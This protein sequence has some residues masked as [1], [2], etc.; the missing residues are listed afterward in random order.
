MYRKVNY[1]LERQPY[2]SPSSPA[3]LLLAFHSSFS[4]SVNTTSVDHEKAKKAKKELIS[5]R[6]ELNGSWVMDALIHETNL[7]RLTIEE[8]FIELHPLSK[9]QQN[10]IKANN[11]DSTAKKTHNTV[12]HER[13]MNPIIVKLNCILRFFSARFLLACSLC[14]FLDGWFMYHVILF[15]PFMCNI[16]HEEWENLDS[17][18]WFQKL[19]N[20][21]VLL[22]PCKAFPFLR[23]IEIAKKEGIIQSYDNKRPNKRD[24]LT[25]TGARYDEIFELDC[26]SLS[27]SD[28]IEFVLCA[29]H[30]DERWWLDVDTGQVRTSCCLEWK[31]YR[32]ADSC[33]WN[34]KRKFSAFSKSR[35]ILYV[36]V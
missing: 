5:T 23:I 10:V 35:P 15:S 16:H 18:L 12:Q 6:D 31:I 4:L 13:E 32:M 2:V 30:E 22:L 17:I 26:L 8:F 21:R 9:P 24:P 11:V 27:H 20:H 7:A 3:S 28:E 29:V 25:E 1:Q 34:V 19:C 36:W 14:R 33:K